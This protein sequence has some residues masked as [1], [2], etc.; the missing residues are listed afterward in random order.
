MSKPF[1]F[2]PNAKAFTPTSVTSSSS[3]PLHQPQTPPPHE[4]LLTLPTELHHQILSHLTLPSLS[5]LGQTSRPY[6]LFSTSLAK[7][8]YTSLLQNPDIRQWPK[9]SESW[10]WLG[11]C[12]FA[13]KVEEG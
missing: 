10:S 2:N 4:T 11:R 8:F 3:P 7:T 6:N 12:G 13:L 5:R 1:T 9:G